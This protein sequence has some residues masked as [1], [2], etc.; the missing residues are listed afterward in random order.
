MDSNN[1]RQ[2]QQIESNSNNNNMVVPGGGGDVPDWRTQ[3]Q[4][5]SRQRIVNKIMETLKRHLPISGPEGLQ[6]LK[7][8]AVRFEEKIYSAATTQS[9]Y[10]R[11]I[12]LKMLTMETK[13]QNNSGAPNPVIGNQNPLDPASLGVQPQVRIP[14]QPQI[15]LP[16][17]SQA[18]QQLMAQGIQ[19]PAVSGGVQSS[20]SLT[21]ANPSV[22]GLNPST[23]P[24]VIG[25]NAN[26]QNMSGITQTS[27]GQGVP[28]NVFTNQQRQMQGRQPQQVVS[29]TNQQ[30]PPNAQQYMFHPNQML[31]QKLQPSHMQSHIQQQQNLL[32]ATNL[33]S[34]Q[35]SL[36]QLQSN[37]STPQQTQPSMMQSASHS[38]F[39]QN[40][41]PLAQQSTSA[42]LQQHPQSVLRQ[43]PQTQQS[44]HQQNTGVHQ[45]QTSIPQ[46]Q[47]Q[48]NTTNMQQQQQN[49][50]IG[51]Q[52]SVPDLQQN[53][54]QLQHQRM[55]GQQNNL[56]N[57]QQ[58]QQLLGQQSNLSNMNPQQLGSQNGVGLQQQ[59]QLVGA[60][61]G[62]S[63]MQSHQ[64]SL[65]M[66]SQQAK[67]GGQ[68]QQAAQASSTLMQI[69]GQ[70]SQSQ[71]QPLQQ[72][73]MPQLGS[74]SAQYPQQMGMQHQPNTIQRD[75][76]QRLNSSGIQP[77]NVIDQKQIQSQRMLPEG[78][79][80]SIDS[81][82]QSGQPSGVDWQED[83]YQKV[84]AMKD[85]YLQDLSEM[86]QKVI[87]KLQQNETLAQ[88]PKE[89]VE[90]IRMMKGF[91]ERVITF[92]QM[93]KGSIPIAHRDKMSS[94]EKQIVAFLNSNRVKKPGPPHQGQQQQL[95]PSVGHNLSMP[96]QQQQQPQSQIPQLQQ[97]DNQMNANMQSINPSNSMAS[98]V[99]SMSHGSL[100]PIQSNMMNPLQSNSTLD[101]A[102]Q[103]NVMG[104]RQQQ[105]QQQQQQQTSM[106]TSQQSNNINT[107][108]QN[109]VNGLQPS[110]NSM[111]LNNNNMLQ[112]QHLKQQQ[113]QQLLQSQQ[114]KQQ[115]HQRQLH[116]QMM[117]KQQQ[118]QQQ[119][120]QPAQ[121]QQLQ[122]KQQQSAQFQANQ[123]PVHQGSMSF[124][125]G[126][127]AQQ[128]AAYQHQQQLK[129][130]VGSQF[131]ISSPQLIQAASPQLSQHSPQID[132]QGLMTSL[133]KSGTPLQS[134]N[135]PFIVP[136][137]STPLAPSP[138]PG[139]NEKQVSGISSLSNA[140]YPPSTLTQAQSLAIG[141]PGISA[142]PLLAEFIGTDGNQGSEQPLERLLKAVK[143]M[144]PKAF[145]ASVSDIGS[146]I[147]MIDRIAGSAPGNGSRAAVG[148]D[149][150]AMTKCRMQA[151][152]FITQDGA[153]SAAS[154][155]MRRETSAMPL[156]A[157]SSVG[158]VNDSL[159]QLNGLELSDL[160]ST[161][162]SRIKRP[163]VEA[164][165]A[166]VEEI[167]EINHR[168]IDTVAEL[169]DEDIEGG[170]GTIVKCSYNAVALSPQLK[171]Q[172]ASA[173]MSPIMPLQ[174]LIPTNYPSCSPVLLDNV[175]IDTSKDYDDLSV[176]T[177][178]RF[179]TSLRSL[180]QPMSL[181]EMVKTWDIC[182]RA[183]IADHAQQ[184]GGGTF[185][186]RYGT[187]KKCVPAT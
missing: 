110:M 113:D 103:Q 22:T 168:L 172:Y 91:L 83:A 163:K 67:V 47:Q 162:T 42:L 116:Q 166:L 130:N 148:E 56:S 178:S 5:D 76:H 158:S 180:S 57:M 94:Y 2:A 78:S 12:S 1:W 25:Q 68:Q 9:D 150:V 45:Q 171:A 38:G 36:M 124:K 81:A 157:V 111:Q 3:L 117:Q 26:L 72:Q 64:P 118:F 107:L 13:S 112:Q 153:S 164:N 182:A 86:H 149:L 106:N 32:Q 37:Q 41:Q 77:Q 133:P 120:Q 33:Q 66:L 95:Q 62:V 184:S 15:S 144:S 141:T 122:Q 129:A 101:M 126:M 177:R 65:H 93:P 90:R 35:Q 146:V 135:S 59:Q 161:A 109:N 87:F 183:V 119:Q 27:V 11:K 19:D 151:R 175:P 160:E 92:L 30:Q 79:S 108:S 115:F 96:Q 50:L 44:L 137:P 99:T 125:Q 155:K 80:P 165:H 58:Q 170:Q 52:N 20:S 104:S 176:K 60:Q 174:L 140:G 139:D 179:S 21:S 142:S 16:N 134:V 34:S 88:A 114:L 173:Q 167:K 185:S 97:H 75:V 159:K 100:P 54:Q 147:S 10:L 23:M 154:K 18:R 17:S 131:P 181:K 127:T 74:Q 4:A 70:Q 49:Q 14:G 31:K 143:S 61:S 46:Q 105:Q 121:Q 69:P 169:S 51:Q 89:Q 128:R 82:S 48:Q 145:S 71:S 28:S 102:Q 55:L 187:W 29:Q 53:Q 63:S 152:N 123:M 40:Q 6:E 84:K 156:N 85:M 136:S 132:Q 39:Q 98:S 73:M 7:K 43:Q 8:I 186:S 24:N 138:L